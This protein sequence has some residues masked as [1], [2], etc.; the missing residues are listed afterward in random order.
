MNIANIILPAIC[1]AAA[2]IVFV[3]WAPELRRHRDE[4]E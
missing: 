1:I 2:L 3:I 4:D